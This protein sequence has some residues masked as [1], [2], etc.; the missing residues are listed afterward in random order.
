MTL[1]TEVI[2]SLADIKY[3]KGDRAPTNANIEE[4]KNDLSITSWIKS[5]Q[6]AIE[7][8]QGKGESLYNTYSTASTLTRNQGIDFKKD[9]NFSLIFNNQQNNKYKYNSETKQL[10]LIEEEKN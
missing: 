8:L 1:L 7:T 9:P 5:P 10:E 3:K 2:T 6:K 4:I